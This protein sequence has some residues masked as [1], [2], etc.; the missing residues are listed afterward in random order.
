MQMIWFLCHYLSF[1]LQNKLNKLDEYCREWGL[2]VNT[3]KTQVMAMT[4]SGKDVPGSIMK[5]GDAALEWVNSYNY[6]GILINANGDFVPTSENL[7]IRGWK[8]SFKIKSAALKYVDV[9]PKLKLKL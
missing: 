8:A 1:F 4:G 6:L 7:C 9:D 2:E 3:K 5:I